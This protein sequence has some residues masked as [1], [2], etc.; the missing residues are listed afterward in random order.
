L[1]C[2][3]HC[4]PLSSHTVN[5]PLAFS[6]ALYC[7]LFVVLYLCSP[8]FFNFI[9]PRYQIARTHL[10]NKADQWQKIAAVYDIIYI[11]TKKSIHN[12][13]KLRVF[14]NAN[15]ERWSAL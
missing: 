7:T 14:P 10:R 9:H 12:R 4:I 15:I 13:A 5:D 6:D 2:A 8:L 1:G 11:D 3:N